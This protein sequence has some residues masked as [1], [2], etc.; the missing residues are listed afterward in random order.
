MSRAVT[1]AVT[2]ADV[3]GAISEGVRRYIERGTF[4]KGDQTSTKERGQGCR[5]EEKRTREA[6]D[7]GRSS[8]CRY[9][10]QLLKIDD[11]EAQTHRPI[12]VLI[13]YTQG[14]Q[15]SPLPS[16]QCTVLTGT[17]VPVLYST[18]LYYCTLSTR[19]RN[20]TRRHL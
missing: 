12:S 16:L 3:R 20:S 19:V 17:G 6:R 13:D 4:K 14:E 9:V 1:G 5:K 2:S 11:S 7:G 18:V 8:Y 15:F 10:E